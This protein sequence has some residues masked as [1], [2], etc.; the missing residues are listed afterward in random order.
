MVREPFARER[1][2]GTYTPEPNMDTHEPNIAAAIPGNARVTNQTLLLANQTLRLSNQILLLPYQEAGAARVT[3]RAAAQ[4]ESRTDESR[5]KTALSGG[6]WCSSY[7]T[8]RSSAALP[9]A[10]WLVEYSCLTSQNFLTSSA[11]QQRGAS[12]RQVASRI[13]L[14]H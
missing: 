8:S 13:F 4:T 11:A 12:P 7:R 10:R 9:R 14:P 1:A 6:R 2:N 3:R 5:T